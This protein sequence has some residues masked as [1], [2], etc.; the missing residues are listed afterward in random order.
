MKNFKPKHEQIQAAN[1]VFMAMAYTETIRPDLEKIQQSLVDFWKPEIAARWIDKGRKPEII[2]SW[3]RLY[4]ASDEDTN[5]I[6]AEY[7][8]EIKK[9]GYTVK[10]V[11]NCPLLEAENIERIAKRLLIDTMEPV[12]GLDTDMIL[13]SAKGLEN[14][15][16]VIDLTLRLLA[17]YCNK[18]LKVA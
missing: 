17:P 7:N 18:D 15:K 12:T 4:L 16:K 2:T 5:I 10:A 9:A 8:D 14:Y 11:G 6:Y 1:A 3:S 13:C